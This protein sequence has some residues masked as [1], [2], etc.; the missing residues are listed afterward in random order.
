MSALAEALDLAEQHDVA[1]TLVG[2]LLRWK[3]RGSVPDVVLAK[4]RA[5][6]PEI[7]DLFKRYRLAADGAL[8]GDALLENLA[9][10]GFRVVR[11]GNWC[12]PDDIAGLGQLPTRL[13]LYAF[14]DLQPVYALALRLLRAPDRLEVVDRQDKAS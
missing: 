6:K 8:M 2:D 11:Y 13:A 12:H 9:A 1:I 7:I 4:L 5:V 10:Q 3:S 14:A